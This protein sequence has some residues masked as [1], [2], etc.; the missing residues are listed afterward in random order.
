M[1]T[2]EATPNASLPVQ[3]QLLRAIAREWAEALAR[4]PNRAAQGARGDRQ[5]RRRA[6]PEPV[7]TP[8]EFIERSLALVRKKVIAS[9]RR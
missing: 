8:D 7:L 1:N 3:Q 5:Q 6:A 9:A 4:Q 2:I